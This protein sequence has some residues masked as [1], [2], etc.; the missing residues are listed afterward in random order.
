VVS[1]VGSEFV[2][3]NR[4]ILGITSGIYGSRESSEVLP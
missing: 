4:F 3:G 2:G 1:I